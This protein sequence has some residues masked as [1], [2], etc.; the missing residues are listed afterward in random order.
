LG[1]QV[2]AYIVQENGTQVA[3]PQP[4]RTSAGGVPTY[5]GSPVQIAVAQSAYS[6]KVLSSLG[7]QVYYKPNN[8]YVSI[9]NADQISYTPNGTG[10]VLTTVGDIL[11]AQLMVNYAALRAYT[12]LAKTVRITGLLATAQ[13]Q[14]IAGFFQYDSTDTTSADNGGTI[15]VGSDGRRWKRQVENSIFVDWFGADKYGVSNSTDAF[16]LAIAVINEQSGGALDLAT[17][18]DYV[19]GKE[20]FVSGTG[21]V[22]THLIQ[23]FE[24]TKPVVVNGNGSIVRYAN[25]LHFGVFNVTTGA[26]VVTTPPYYGPGYAEP[27]QC[28]KFAGCESAKINDIELDGNIINAVIG[29]QWGDSGWQLGHI[30]FSFYGCKQGEAE[31]VYVHH[32]GVDGY[33]LEGQYFNGTSWVLLDLETEQYPH[34]FINVKSYYNGR[35]GCSWTG[36][37]RA[38]FINCDF[39]H[40][41]KN[42]VVQSAPSAGLD[43]EPNHPETCSHGTFINCNFYDNFGV[44]FL[45]VGDVSYCT[46]IDCTSIGTTNAALWAPADYMKYVGCT[47]VGKVFYPGPVTGNMEKTHSKFYGTR[48]SMVSADSPTGGIFGSFSDFTG[49]E[50]AYFDACTF[51]ADGSH[52]LPFSLGT[53]GITYNNCKLFQDSPVQCYTNGIFTGLTHF[54]FAGPYSSTDNE[55]YGRFLLNG[56]ELRSILPLTRNVNIDAFNGAS[57]Y[58]ARIA[59]YSS[60]PAWAAAVGG[61]VQTDI[62]FN[63][64]AATGQPMGWVCTVTGNPGTWRPMVNLL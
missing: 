25:G 12:G 21:W 2:Q 46:L 40:T 14:G 39:A 7:V 17:G 29:G 23:F 49:S 60:G 24:C 43:I 57:S 16:N 33:V 48:F 11:D 62:V 53:T 26:P 42:G 58:T 22:A 27:G 32:F 54:N 20:T 18:G 15:I 4:I 50:Y 64:N 51:E 38:T 41:G 47:F 8:T 34:L 56:N 52:Q 37:N 6:I 19:V 31:N 1:N 44:G 59:I 45:T 61:A 63:A 3:V 5:N 35:Q 13:P 28:F 30:G 10:A 36:G 9:A 55:N